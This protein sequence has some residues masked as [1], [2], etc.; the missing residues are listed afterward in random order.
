[1]DSNGDFCD[2]KGNACDS[3]VKLLID[4]KEVFRTEDVG[5]RNYPKY[6]QEYS[7]GTSVSKYSKIVI[8]LWD[9]DINPD[10]LM[11]EWT[12]PLSDI[13]GKQKTYI[14]SKTNRLN[15][16]DNNSSVRNSITFVAALLPT[17][18]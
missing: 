8:Q 6:N 3:Y 16:D 2:K 12:I 13:D 18:S 5:N 7:T 14:G 10:D 17:Y 15:D 11:D 9:A 4:G 1:M